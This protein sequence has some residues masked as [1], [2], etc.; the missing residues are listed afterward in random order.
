MLP[1]GSDGSSHWSSSASATSSKEKGGAQNG[2]VVYV[3]LGFACAAALTYQSHYDL[4]L[5]TFITLSVALQ[6]FAYSLLTLKV[7][8]QHSVKG[9]SG[10]ALQCHAVVYT[11]RLCS[12][13]WLKGYIP[14]DTTGD[15]LYQLTDILSLTTVLYL[16]Y[17]VFKKHKQT[18]QEEHDSFE[19]GYLLSSCFLLAVLLHPDLND[20]PLFDTLWTFALYVDVVAMMPQLWM[21][22]KVGGE[23]DA[24]NGHYIAAIAASRA[25]SLSFWYYGYSELAPED[26]SFNVSGWAIL[27]AHVVQ[28]L[29]LLDFIILYLKACV[30]GCISAVT[31]GTCTQPTIAMPTVYD[32]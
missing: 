16:V 24:L 12:T 14:S 5:S 30:F 25:V 11:F 26:G 23:L 13:T 15:Y 28:M 18:Y 9:I 7:V 6:L 21:M 8:Q 27:G 22:S 10:K 17:L 3:Y 2:S 4:G 20:R 1:T 32:M 29:L 19:I 31:T